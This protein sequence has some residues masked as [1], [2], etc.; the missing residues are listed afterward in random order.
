MSYCLFSL[1]GVCAY[2]FCLRKNK[3]KK[4]FLKLCHH[5]SVIVVIYEQIKHF[6][7]S[8]PSKFNGTAVKYNMLFCNE[9]YTKDNYVTHSASV[10][11]P[12]KRKRLL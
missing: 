4:D 9:E 6:N 5:L 2:L 7:F 8:L 1:G 10:Y 3:P 12:K 11:C